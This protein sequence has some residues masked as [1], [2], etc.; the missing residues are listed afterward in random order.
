M[1]EEPKDTMVIRHQPATL[2]CRA[3][4]HPPPVIS[5]YKDGLPLAHGSAGGPRRV[6][7][8]AGGL[9]FLRATHARRDTD[10]GV[11]FCEATNRLGVA[12]SGNATLTVAGK[13]T[14]ENCI[15]CE[16]MLFAI[17]K[18]IFL[19]SAMWLVYVIKKL[20]YVLTIEPTIFTIYYVVIY[21][22]FDLCGVAEVA[23]ASAWES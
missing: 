11:Y 9:F 16:F 6:L 19:I 13:L 22:L 10:Q 14:R 17:S 3:E 4:G 15:I 8:P 18:N 20:P 21:R 5:W 2:E 1:V 23:N 12:R 7:L